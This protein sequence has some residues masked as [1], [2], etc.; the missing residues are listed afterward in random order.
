MCMD[1][2]IMYFYGTCLH[3]LLI[4]ARMFSYNKVLRSCQK[5]E[6]ADELVI[7]LRNPSSI[8]FGVYMFMIER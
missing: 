2:Y 5:L 7:Q 1:V 8:D 4:I 6:L 3:L